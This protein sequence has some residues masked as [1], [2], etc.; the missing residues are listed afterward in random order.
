MGDRSASATGNPA[1]FAWIAFGTMRD[2]M[3]SIGSFL[4]LLALTTIPCAHAQEKGGKLDDLSVLY[5]PT[6]IWQALTMDKKIKAELKLT[7]DQE[8]QIQPVMKKW[9][10]IQAQNANKIF[11]MTGPDK[12]DK[13]RALSQEESDEMMRGLSQTLSPEQVTRLKQIMVQRLGITLF[14][15]REIRDSFNL[16][17][18]KVANL[19]ATYQQQTN[20]LAKLVTSGKISREEGRKQYE[21]MGRYLPDKVLAVLPDDQRKKVKEML[22]TPFEGK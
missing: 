8:T 18:E 14:H 16:T 9:Q 3:K 13:I 17:S 6:A 12:Y 7:K 5:S 21:A 10:S 15:I 20:D 22:G 2:P 11:K 1:V 19:D 4:L